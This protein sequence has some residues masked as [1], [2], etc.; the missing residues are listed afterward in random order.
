L[1]KRKIK[2]EKPQKRFGK[3]EMLIAPIAIGAGML[4]TFVIVPIFFPP[5]DPTN[6]CLKAVNV[7]NFQLFPR[8]QV[9]VDGKQVWLPADVGRAPQHGNPCIRPIRTD[10]IGDVV[11]IEYIRPIEFTMAN[12]M[13]VYSHNSTMI[14]VVDNSTTPDHPVNRTLDLSQYNV[15]YS[16][17]SNGKF[18]PVQKPS[19]FPPFPADNSMVARIE[20]SKK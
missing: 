12:F 9:F 17:Y 15:Q 14:T 10:Q 18:V 1:P 3:K 2:E 19:D 16:Y 20:L 13:K 7:E 6:V 11:H 5:P 4:V 8:V